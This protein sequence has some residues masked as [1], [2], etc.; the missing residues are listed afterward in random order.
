MTDLAY[1]RVSSI[2]QTLDQQRDALLAAGIKPEHIYEDTISGTKSSRPG[3]DA[4]LS[5]A[6]EGDTVTVVRLDRLGRTVPMILQTLE[7]LVERG[8][9]LKSLSE[10][11]DMGTVTG[12]LLV[13]I[14]AGFAQY[15]RE[16]QRERVAEARAAVEKR[17]G[18]WGRKA[19]LSSAQVAMARA[20][21]AA[22]QSPSEIAKELGCSRATLYRVTSD[23]AA[24]E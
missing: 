6:R 4:L 3:L 12:R 14:L 10:S 21:R 7:L 11:I 17:G 15:E 20:A 18:K 2:G 1:C 23:L 9:V 8:I 16:L 5:Y 24:T 22:G 19:V 13:T